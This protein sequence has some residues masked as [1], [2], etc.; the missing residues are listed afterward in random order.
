MVLC[1]A[2]LTAEFY[3][4]APLRDPVLFFGITNILV[5]VWEKHT[6]FQDDQSEYY[7]GVGRGWAEMGRVEVQNPLNQM[8]SEAIFEISFAVAATLMALSN[9]LFL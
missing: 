6:A 8:W 3:R 1:A 5:L 4:S 2:A 9:S 7:G